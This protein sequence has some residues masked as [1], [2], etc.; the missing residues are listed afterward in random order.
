MA[1]NASSAPSPAVNRAR[2][3]GDTPDGPH[4]EP[5]SSEPD[6]IQRSCQSLPGKVS[7]QSSTSPVAA[8]A[9]LRCVVADADR[10]PPASPTSSAREAPARAG[11]GGASARSATAIDDD[12]TGSSPSRAATGLV[13]DWLETFPGSD[14]QDRWILSGSDE[15]GSGWGPSGVSPGRRARF[16]AGLGALLALRAIRPSY[17]WLF[18]SRMLGAYDLYRR[19]N[20]TATFGR[21]HRQLTEHGGCDEYTRDALNLVTRMVI[22]TGKDVLDIDLADVTAYAQARRASGRPVAALPL[23]YQALHAMGGLTG[24]PATLAQSRTPG[25]LTAAQLVDRYHVA[26]RDVRDVLV[27][28][29]A[30]RAAV[31]DY[32]SVVNQSQMLVA[33]FWTDL[34]R[35]HPGICSLSLPDDVAQGWKQR[36]HV[37]PDGRPRLNCHAVLLAVRSFYL[38]L[39]QW[40]LEDPARWAPWAAPCPIREADV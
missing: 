21:L 15:Q 27:H 33:L 7:S 30:E 38:D 39:R 28:Y 11:S 36:I 24:A 19:H 23:A 5:C 12:R 22:V 8:C 13:L 26:D 9:R 10:S 40:S 32:A 35:H 31:L 25:R 29:L 2:R 1:R 6:R 18:A 20:Q 37:L 3:P 34:E 17:R 14:W 16:T 4:P